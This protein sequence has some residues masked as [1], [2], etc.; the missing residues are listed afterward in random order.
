MNPQHPTLL[1]AGGGKFLSSV[2]LFG[3][4]DLLEGATDTP[5]LL[6]K[7]LSIVRSNA[8]KQHLE[9]RVGEAFAFLH[10]CPHLRWALW[11]TLHSSVLVLGL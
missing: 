11:L 8:C 9:R 3:S 5:H 7:L 10:T 4:R 6:L 2:W 1:R